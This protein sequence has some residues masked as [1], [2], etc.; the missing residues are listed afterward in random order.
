MKLHYPHI[1]L[2]ALLAI[3]L[4]GC[5]PLG[6]GGEETKEGPQVRITAPSEEATFGQDE[7]I[8]CQAEV[9]PAERTREL[10]W[11]LGDTPVACNGGELD[12]D[13]SVILPDAYWL[14]AELPGESASAKTQDAVRVRITQT[15]QPPQV[16]I[17]LPSRDTFYFEQGAPMYLEASVEKGE[18]GIASDIEWIAGGQVRTTSQSGEEV[19]VEAQREFSEIVAKVTDAEGFAGT[20]TLKIEVTSELLLV[21]FGNY[22][23]SETGIYLVSA[24]GSREIEPL[25]VLTAN[26][27]YLQAEFSPDGRKVA[28]TNQSSCVSNGSSVFVANYDFSDPKEIGCGE[29]NTAS[30]IK[31][32]PDGD[33]LAFSGKWINPEMGPKTTFFTV[34]LQTGRVER[35]P[36]R[37][38]NSIHSNVPCWRNLTSFTF[39]LS[40][41]G[42]IFG[43]IN[44]V[45]ASGTVHRHVVRIDPATA[46][47]TSI[48]KDAPYVSAESLAP[49]VHDVSS[50]GKWLAVISVTADDIPSGENRTK[51]RASL[52]KTD[53]S[54]DY[55]KFLSPPASHTYIGTWNPDYPVFN[56]ASDVVYHT[57]DA[58]R[59]TKSVEARDLQGN[60]LNSRSYDVPYDVIVA[61]TN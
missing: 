30:A 1:L 41:D 34:D 42:K 7:T 5:E 6:I 43:S 33:K 19:A 39:G 61:I 46:E 38:C 15:Y 3:A 58:G 60:L 16:E 27:S 18:F 9:V 52:L 50:N 22:D 37:T 36:H 57:A 29:Y 48:W 2:A 31:W 25:E 59:F 44:K 10:V 8:P 13:P 56:P 32:F 17:T 14:T 21:S 4:A 40:P 49:T 55:P 35:I 51:P 54:M 53:G 26:M 23:N 28:F 11:R 47:K 24:P 45:D 20:D 12:Y